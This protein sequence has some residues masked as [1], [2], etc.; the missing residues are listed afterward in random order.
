VHELKE[1]DKQILTAK[2][3]NN[4][5]V[6]ICFNELKS[7]SINS[8]AYYMLENILIAYVVERVKMYGKGK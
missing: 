1:V 4:P 7:V 6:N 8:T 3:Y 5:I 2:L